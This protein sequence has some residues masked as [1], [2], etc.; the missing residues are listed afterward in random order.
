M[1]Y[2]PQSGYLGPPELAVYDART[3]RRRGAWT[4]GAVLPVILAVVIVAFPKAGIPAGGIPFNFSTLIGLPLAA[5]GWLYALGNLRRPIDMIGGMLIFVALVL[6][7]GGFLFAITHHNIPLRDIAMMMF[8]MAAVFGLGLAPLLRRMPEAAIRSVRFIRY[9]V[10]FLLAYAMLQIAFGADAVAINYVTAI[11]GADFEEVLKKHNILHGL[12]TYKI[13]AT[14]QNGNMFSIG[15]ILTFPLALHSLRTLPQKLILLALFNIVIVYTASFSAYVGALV[16]NVMFFVTHQRRVA[17]YLPAMVLAAALGGWLYVGQL[18][19]GATNCALVNLLTSRAINRNLSEN[20]RW[21][22][23]S[24]WFGSLDDSP[25]TLLVGE[26][27][28]TGPTIREVFVFSVAQN[29]GAIVLILMLVFIFIYLRPLRVRFYKAGF[30]AYMISSFGESAFWAT[31]TAFIIGILLAIIYV[32]DSQEEEQ[33]AQ[34]L[35]SDR[36]STA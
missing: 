10:I 22:K 28:Q 34:D 1:T 15:I 8:A 19:S 4:L 21:D 14:Y 35:L 32:L 3:G 12:D 16:I 18:C 29:F 9:A 23:V 31:P 5:L 30:Y 11:Y 26:I 13:F 27:Y 33:A 17:V 36:R 6:W 20:E 24:N 25:L 7:T 2:T